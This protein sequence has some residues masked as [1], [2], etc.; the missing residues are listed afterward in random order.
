MQV[1]IALGVLALLGLMAAGVA[2][3]RSAP[4]NSHTARLKTLLEAG[5]AR[6]G[7]ALKV[8]ED[9]TRL[10][11][12]LA[13]AQNLLRLLALGIALGG[14]GGAF[15]LAWPA[16]GRW[17]GVLV[18]A[19]KAGSAE[20]LARRSHRNRSAGPPSGTIIGRWWRCLRRPPW[21]CAGWGVSARRRLLREGRRW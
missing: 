13:L 16:W 15:G 20:L 1:E 18:A 6:A 5:E 2:L 17:F 10:M 7:W 14:F 3:G 12:A 8:A 11:V 21:R 4:V 19:A 9:A